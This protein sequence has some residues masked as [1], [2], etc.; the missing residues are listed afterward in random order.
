MRQ[1]TQPETPLDYRNQAA[2]PDFDDF[3]KAWKR[4]SE[5]ARRDLRMEPDL[6]YGAHARQVADV[7]PSTKS[8]APVFIFIHGGWWYFLDKSDFSSVARP[9]VERDAVVVNINYP[10]APAARMAEIVNSVRDAVVWV[11][12]NATRWGGDPG[13]LSVGGHS[14]GGH[15]ST[16][17]ALTD[18]TSRGLDTNP[19]RVNCS[20]SGLF[21]LV[22]LVA[23]PHN[24]RIQMS[25]EDAKANS[26][27]DEVVRNGTR[28]IVCV[29]TSE[30]SGF[31]WQHRIFLEA[32]R[33]KQVPVVDAG[34][35]GKHHFNVID[36]LGRAD[37]TMFRT[38]W[39]EMTS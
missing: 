31:L 16:S 23:A 37:S 24:E 13:N 2:V 35:P 28:H 9:F 22:P 18:W 27:I 8:G 34:I 3:F 25:A 7:F 6:R 12:D 15:L 38:L 39:S 11:R 5:Q 32:C 19:I 17:M 1:H 14:A 36:E 26:P 33:R 10:L 21:D 20:V 30:T 29:G 4:E